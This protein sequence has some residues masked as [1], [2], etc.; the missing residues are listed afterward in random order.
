MSDQADTGK[1]GL[2]ELLD[3]FTHSDTLGT[4]RENL[5]VPVSVAILPAAI[6]AWK[7]L[8]TTAIAVAGG[9]SLALYVYHL[10]VLE[11]V[12]ILQDKSIKRIIGLDP[13]FEDI[14]KAPRCMRMRVLRRSFLLLLGMAWVALTCVKLHSEKNPEPTTPPYSE[15]AA[16]SPQR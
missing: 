14:V 10:L 3:L 12:R 15:P 4:T 11:R 7:D 5:F 8:P 6:L 13:T 2:A 9:T 16:R 1:L